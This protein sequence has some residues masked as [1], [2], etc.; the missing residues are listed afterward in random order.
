MSR[1]Q[2]QETLPLIGVA[3]QQKI[4]HATVALVGVGALGS[5]SA[6]LLARAGIGKLLLI[7]R[8]LVD[9]TNLTRQSLYAEEDVGT[10]KAFAAK[11]RIHALNSD[12]QVAAFFEDVTCDTITSLLTEA[13]I[14]LDGTDNMDTRFLINDYCLS[15]GKPW[16]AAGAITTKG[17]VLPI[18]PG[19]PCF[20][21]VFAENYAGALETCDTAG[22]LNTITTTIAAL[23]T[24]LCLKL[25]LGHS[26]LPQMTHINLWNGS[27][28]TLGIT[29]RTDCPA[30]HGNYEY[31]TGKKGHDTIRICSTNTYLIRTPLI[32]LHTL[33][34]TL[35]T[36][37][38]VTNHTYYLTFK[39]MTIFPNRILIRAPNE[40]EAQKLFTTYIGH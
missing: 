7:D 5:V 37:D 4:S 14:I 2:R 16:I 18:T 10:P 32:N 35:S 40:Q 15:T 25:I 34:H 36:I 20:R 13:H 1:Y 27:Y 17:Y 26:I 9:V 31:I 23:Q 22:V 3:G 38:T 28:A 24:T 21:C 33:Q 12:V 6:E 11:K 39:T 29:Q 19:N 8:D 30:C